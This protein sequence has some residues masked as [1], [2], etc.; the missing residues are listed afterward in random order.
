MLALSNFDGETLT[1]RF[2][3]ER[4][5]QVGPFDFVNQLENDID[6]KLCQELIAL[7]SEAD[8]PSLRASKFA[9][10]MGTSAP[11]KSKLTLEADKSVPHIPKLISS[12]H[13][14]VRRADTNSPFEYIVQNGKVFMVLKESRKSI[15]LKLAFINMEP[16]HVLSME[17]AHQ[18]SLGKFPL[19]VGNLRDCRHFVRSFSQT[20]FTTVH[21]ANCSR[22]LRKSVISGALKASQ[23][24]TIVIALENINQLSEDAV[25]IL[26]EELAS[27]KPKSFPRLVM[28]STIEEQHLAASS[29][30]FVVKDI[31][32]RESAK[33]IA[34]KAINPPLLEVSGVGLAASSRRFSTRRRE[35][36]LRERTPSEMAFD[37]MHTGGWAFVGPSAKKAL[38]EG[39]ELNQA[40][41]TWIY[42]DAFT[43]DQLISEPAE[44][45][46]SI[47]GYLP[48]SL[49]ETIK[50]DSRSSHATLTPMT[51]STSDSRRVGS[52]SP[53]QRYI[54]FYT[55]QQF[56]LHFPILSA[57]FCANEHSEY[58]PPYITLPDGSNFCAA[59]NMHFAICLPAK[60]MEQLE[61][62]ERNGIRTLT[63]DDV[64]KQSA[65]QKWDLWRR[66]FEE[67]LVE[68]N[69][70]EMMRNTMEMIVL[71]LFEAFNEVSEDFDVIFEVMLQDLKEIRPNIFAVNYGELIRWASCSACCNWLAVFID[72][73]DQ[74]DYLVTELVAEA[75]KNVSNAGKLPDQISSW[76]LSAL[77]F[78]RWVRW[79]DEPNVV[80]CLE[81]D[82]CISDIVVMYPDFDRIITYLQR[83]F[84]NSNNILLYGSDYCGKTTLIKR[85]VKHITSLD[86]RYH[87]IWLQSADRFDA[88]KM[89]NHFASILR[90]KCDR[91]LVLI[92]DNFHFVE[93]IL[94]L[95]EMYCE[96]N[97]FID[98]GMPQFTDAKLQIILVMREDEYEKLSTNR[99]LVDKFRLVRMQSLSTENLQIIFEQI[100]LWH[101]H[102]KT[103]NAEYQT[104][105]ESMS[106]ATLRVIQLPSVQMPHLVLAQRIAKGMMFAYP[107]SIPDLDGM[108]RLWAHE[109]MRCV[110][111]SLTSCRQVRRLIEVLER[112]LKEVFS[113][114]DRSFA[115]LIGAQNGEKNATEDT[116]VEGTVQER[117]SILKK[118]IFSEIIA[119]DG[120]EGIPYT[121]VMENFLFEFRRVYTVTR[122][123]NLSIT[124]YTMSHVQRVMRVCRQSSEHMALVGHP[125]SGRT[126]CVRLATFALNGQTL[127]VY[128]D[129]SSHETFERSWR[130]A[131]TRAAQLAT[132]T[133]HPINV[134]MRLD[135]CQDQVKPEWL[136]M[137]KQ[138]L[139]QP[140]AGEMV[141]DETIV[142]N[143]ERIIEHEKMLAT[144]MQTSNI[145]LPG[146]RSCRF[147]ISETIHSSEALEKILSARV[148][149]FVHFFFVIGPRTIRYLQWCTIDCYLV[150][151]ISLSAFQL[152]GNKEKSEMCMRVLAESELP[153]PQRLNVLKV[154]ERLCTIFMDNDAEASIASERMTPPESRVHFLL[155][156]TFVKAYLQQKSSIGKRKNILKCA[157]ETIAKIIDMSC[158][159]EDSV[160]NELMRQLDNAEMNLIALKSEYSLKI[161]AFER[162]KKKSRSEYDTAS[163][164][165]RSYTAADY[166]K[167]ASIKKPM[168]GVR[169]T[170]EAVRC[171]VDPT[172]RPR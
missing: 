89:Q 85:F 124:G 66:R 134:L 76:K 60:Q 24:E 93:A 102:T 86:D 171:L 146:Q 157:L 105:L 92:I 126:Q 114:G 166:R 38:I 130:S 63:F 49:K 17:F 1:I 141:T 82:L 152:L 41:A 161:S 125:G 153:L 136:D 167:L 44:L 137:L 67:L 70:I 123:L 61:W 8:E 37:A 51:T 53:P 164:K 32:R 112:C 54:I 108:I 158:A 115:K 52:I 13:S 30:V 27:I 122:D 135:F 140:I 169:F 94:P 25:E 59:R 88:L 3:L 69:F 5:R 50:A 74:L 95:L 160:G 151:R 64:P 46:T 18:W 143:G 113:W 103:F 118:L 131:V 109:T 101:L 147:L 56:A 117:R 91:K 148:S 7:M 150:S 29:A 149:D 107:D 104:L 11:H 65:S 90:I 165:L 21:Y 129:A 36:S 40:N 81:K 119:P 144:A 155:C 48:L 9:R 31:G 22:R 4:M 163:E 121:C 170:I 139:Q 145:R 168:I 133:N 172:F 111:D 72:K 62:I 110:A 19:L 75:D 138:W 116:V 2:E 98:N 106:S 10:D 87:F 23:Q 78:S 127:S 28:F 33:T 34:P 57:L 42:L 84:T 47:T 97:L 80:S 73:L 35:S 156:K 26:L 14:C 15:L 16:V 79:M 100:V 120:I 162:M 12:L 43:V 68:E 132:N 6:K 83:L 58:P 96:H 159:G 77:D 154:L 55:L 39:I 128:P 142:S 71:P 45:G 99:I 20:L